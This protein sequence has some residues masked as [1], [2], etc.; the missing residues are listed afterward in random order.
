VAYNVIAG[1]EQGSSA[2]ALG[3]NEDASWLFISVPGSSSMTGWISTLSGFSM[4]E[5]SVNNL[6]IQ[7]HPPAIP[8]YI[9]NC[10]FHPM[11]VTPGDVLLAEQTSAPEN[12]G[13]FNPGPYRVYDRSVSDSLVKEFRLAEGDTID[14][15]TDGLN[16]TYACP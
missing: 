14:I 4:L 3:R 9:R 1:L 16:S 7:P 6:V 10:T 2:T 15:L 8:A 5:G 11:L 13:Q 12:M